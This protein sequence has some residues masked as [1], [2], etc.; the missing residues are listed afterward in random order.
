MQKMRLINDRLKGS[1]ERAMLIINESIN[2][3]LKYKEQRANFDPS[4][5]GI[6]ILLNGD[7]HVKNP[8]KPDEPPV[9]TLK[10][11]NFFGMADVIKMQQF[12]WFGDIIAGQPT[13]SPAKKK[14]E[15]DKKPTRAV[16]VKSPEES[17]TCLF[18]P[19]AKLYLIP[20]FDWQRLRVLNSQDQQIRN[21]RKE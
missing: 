17:V 9:T 4:S 12:S 1:N 14:N 7:A 5:D 16:G 20:Y 18:L 15:I 3:L 21:L 19:M 8:I 6:Y 11:Y 10:R 2:S 13:N